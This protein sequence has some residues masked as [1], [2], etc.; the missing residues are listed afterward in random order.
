[1]TDTAAI[2]ATIY[3]IKCMRAAIVVRYLKTRDDAMRTAAKNAAWDAA[4]GVQNRRLTRMLN[5]AIKQGQ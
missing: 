2:T 4:W 5:A 1:M 3:Q